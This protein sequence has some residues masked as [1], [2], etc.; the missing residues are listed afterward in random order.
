MHPL[1]AKTFGGLT[2]QYYFRQFVFGL[3]FPVFILL[4]A[5]NSTQ[6]IKIGMIA[7]MVVNSILYPYS[8]FV[9][10]SIINFIMGQNVILVNAIFLLFAKLTTILLCWL[11]AIFIAPIGLA[12]LYYYHSKV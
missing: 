10:E 4:M 12:Y 3:V 1:I 2:P 11:F 5:S 7:F 6:P 9:Y 8:R